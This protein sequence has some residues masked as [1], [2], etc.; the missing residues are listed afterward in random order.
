MSHE[1]RT[2]L[3]AIIGFSEVMMQEMFGPL[4]SARYVE[5]SR[6]V[7]ESGNHLLELI[8]GVLDMSKIEAGKFELSEEVFD[9]NAV[10]EAS[11]RFLKMPAERAGV[12]LRT[13]VAQ[14]AQYIFADK[15]AIKQILVN[16]LSNGVKFTPKGGEVVI[17]A[18]RDAKG[19]EITVTDTGV[20]IPEKALMRLGQPFEQVEG[21]H[22]K[23][24]EG[25][26]LGLSLVKALTAMHGGE[27][28]IESTLGVGTTVRI[29]LPYAVVGEN[30]ERVAPES[31]QPEALR[32]AA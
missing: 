21:E 5:Y 9:L 28:V 10:A 2:P 11:V 13:Q 30:G 32:G 15:R 14:T 12:A 25:T 1:L 27:A 3:N 29:R 20:G 31:S 17:R 4:G 7:H 19:I 26:G 23:K 6:L 18:A 22:V 24:K 16:L 8:N